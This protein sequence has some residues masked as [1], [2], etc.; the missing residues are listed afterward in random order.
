MAPICARADWKIDPEAAYLHYTS[1]ETING[2]EFQD[3][4]DAVKGS[5]DAAGGS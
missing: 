5:A 4:P 3:I 1:N 2:V